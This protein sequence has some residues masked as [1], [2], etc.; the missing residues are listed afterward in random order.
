MNREILFIVEQ[1]KDAY[2][3]DPWFGRNLKALLSEV[4][5]QTAFVKLKGQHSILELL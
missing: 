1:L 4:D 2:E 3:G 5:E